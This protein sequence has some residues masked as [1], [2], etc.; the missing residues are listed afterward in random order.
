VTSYN[1]GQR[2]YY[3][4][5]G[6]VVN[7]R[8][9][10]GNQQT[11][12]WD[13]ENHLS[14]VSGL[15]GYYENY[16]YDAN[17]QRVKKSNGIGGVTFYPNAYY[18]VTNETVWVDDAVPGGSTLAWDYDG[19][20]WQSGNPV[21]ATAY[22]YSPSNSGLHQHYFYGATETLSVGTGDVLYAYIYLDPSALPQQIML[23]WNDGDWEQRAYWG[24]NLINAGTNGTVSRRYMGA[25]PSA[26][27]WVRLEVPASL[28]GLEGVTI[29]G[30]AFTLYG[31]HA[32]WDRAGVRHNSWR[33]TKNYHFNG[34]VVATR[35]NGVLSYMH[36]DRGPFGRGST[37]ATSNSS[38]TFSG[39]EW[40]HAYGRYRGGHE[41]GTENRFTGQKLDATG[42]MY[43]NARY[44]DP[45][46]G[47]F[48]SPDTLVPDPTD[49]F[50]Y[51]RY[52]YVRGNPMKY[53]DPTGHCYFAADVSVGSFASFGCGGGGLGG[54]AGAATAIKLMVDA[55]GAI[56]AG[57]TVAN[58]V[59]GHQESVALPEQNKAEVNGVPLVE[60]TT[61]TNATT[62]VPDVPSQ[63]VLADP[64]TT[65]QTKPLL[66]ETTPSG[67]RIDPGHTD[68]IFNRRGFTGEELDDIIDNFDEVF[69]QSDGATV[70]LK[71]K[72]NGNYDVVITGSDDDNFIVTA[73]RNLTE[74]E[75]KTKIREGDWSQ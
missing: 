44:Y 37:V 57:A 2:Y 71:N 39:Q 42:L 67:R 43:Y 63:Q 19:W 29:N 22:H 13:H 1:G 6:N 49:V 27:G 68:K 10:Y 48:L 11:L 20:N 5:N 35:K 60:P 58:T 75:R 23:Q 40:Y 24:Q 8:W 66:F 15:N 21:S 52:M 65:E 51:N 55:V 14:N 72:S 12:S 32:W 45:E 54:G 59:Q 34:Q 62:S 9:V 17:G 30:M 70:H 46:L 25:I 28:V 53:N 41:L 38:G 33:A 16:L 74:K 56:F 47:H 4:S 31:G 61:N 26:T 18:E 3:D 50:S 7:R 64:L 69:F 36:G 73:I